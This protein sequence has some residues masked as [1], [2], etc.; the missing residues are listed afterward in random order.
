MLSVIKKFADFDKDSL[1]SLSDYLDYPESK[2]CKK[3]VFLKIDTNENKY[4]GTELQDLSK[5]RKEL[6]LYPIKAARPANGLNQTPTV[7]YN[8]YDKS[9]I[10]KIYN[11]FFDNKDKNDLFAAV[12]KILDE[13]KEKIE[14][15]LSDIQKE[16]KT[17]FLSLI[18]DDK[19]LGRIEIFRNIVS[20]I[21]DQIKIKYNE[22][23]YLEGSYCALCMQKKDKVYGFAIPYT[24]FNV[25]NEAFAYNFKQRNAVKQFPVCLDCAK[26]IRGKGKIYLEEEMKFNDI[27]GNTYFLFP[28]VINS[29]DNEALKSYIKIIK[30]FRDGVGKDSTDTTAEEVLVEKLQSDKNAMSFTLLFYQMDTSKF[31][32]L[33]SI[34]EVLPSN[35]KKF[36]DA[37]NYVNDLFLKEKIEIYGYKKGGKEKE[38]VPIKFSYKILQK[39]FENQKIDFK[40]RSKRQ[41]FEILDSLLN[42]KPVSYNYLIDTFILKDIDMPKNFYDSFLILN[43]FLKLR[44]TNGGDA[45]MSDIKTQYLDDFCMQFPEFFNKPIKKAIFGIGV[46]TEQLAICQKIERGNKAIYRSLKEFKLDQSYI[47]NKLFRDVRY[48]RNYYDKYPYIFADKLGEEIDECILASSQ[49]K[50]DPLEASYVFTAGLQLSQRVKQKFY[51]LHKDEIRQKN[52]KENE[53]GQSNDAN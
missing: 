21:E 10:K 48:K 40:M 46:L 24:F 19:Y 14:I 53:E 50:L 32:I 17:F 35:L 1:D 9:Y 51:E 30:D 11:W 13:N 52:S 7:V 22:K 23:S 31:N 33:A 8:S 26:K 4:F 12:Y 3:A 28:E 6:Y 15:E 47:V 41:F 27:A 49:E 18:I 25:D 34:E 39:L 45:E 36:Y 5:D 29:S 20:D 37:V 42:F 38:S 44:L 16:I 2:S 43:I